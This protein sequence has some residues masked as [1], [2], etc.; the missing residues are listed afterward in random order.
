M[1]FIDP[2]NLTNK[3][4]RIFHAP[5]EFRKGRLVANG[6]DYFVFLTEDNEYLY[7]PTSHLKSMIHDSYEINPVSTTE[8]PIPSYLGADSFRG[9]LKKMMYRKVQVDEGSRNGIT[10]VICNLFDDHLDMVYEHELIKVYISHIKAVRYAAANKSNSNKTDS[11]KTDSNKTNEQEKKSEVKQ[12]ETAEPQS[13]NTVS[14]VQQNNTNNSSNNNA[15]VQNNAPQ[16]TAAQASV[17][18]ENNNEQKQDSVQTQPKIKKRKVRRFRKRRIKR[19]VVKS[20]KISKK[21]QIKTAVKLK[22]KQF[23]LKNTFKGMP[24]KKIISIRKNG[25]THNGSVSYS[26][27]TF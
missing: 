19:A 23:N 8:T 20:R 25:K 16:N 12:E 27:Y 15:A 24:K 11:N 10:G 9:I 4:I 13:S 1:A 14:E 7:C 2:S 6:N 17:N 22:R 5:P 26:V 21:K 18:T 3:M